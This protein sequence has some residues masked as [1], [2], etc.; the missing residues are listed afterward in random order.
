MK[1]ILCIHGVGGK[2]ATI[3]SWGPEWKKAIRSRCNIPLKF[4]FLEMDDLFCESRYRMDGIH[5][6]QAIRLYISSWI[7]SEWRRAFRDDA[8][9]NAVRLYAGMPAQYITDDLLREKLRTRLERMMLQ[10]RADAVYAHSLGS[11]VAYDTFRSSVNCAKTILVTS[12][13]QLGHPCLHDLY[14]GPLQPL[15]VK[16]WINLHNAN[17]KLFAS[18]PLRVPAHNFIEE[19]TPFEFGSLSH[20][21]LH[22]IQQSR[23]AWDIIRGIVPTEPG[24][25]VNGKMVKSSVVGVGR[26]RPLPR[27]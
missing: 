6:L 4:A 7:S 16:T 9:F 26:D 21:A 8:F 15:P 19:K 25:Q 5:Y 1:R 11:M 24:I 22:Y 2:D 14:G 3:A 20:D 27:S 23:L 13:S 10:F 12:G 17:D 18:R